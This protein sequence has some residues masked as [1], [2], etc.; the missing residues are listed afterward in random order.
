MNI[1][2]S[3]TSISVSKQCLGITREVATSEELDKQV[4]KQARNT[5]SWHA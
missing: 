2:M 5:P 1:Y 4:N 3:S